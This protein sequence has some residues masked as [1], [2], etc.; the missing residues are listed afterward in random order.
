MKWFDKMAKCTLA[1]VLAVTLC[2]T[3]FAGIP[4]FAVNVKHGISYEST[5]L[6]AH[7]NIVSLPFSTYI[8]AYM[9]IW[10]AVSLGADTAKF[11]QRQIANEL[12]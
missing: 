2:L 8:A 11:A 3:S 9:K 1:I 5:E 10:A 7:L 6:F 4:A 12:V